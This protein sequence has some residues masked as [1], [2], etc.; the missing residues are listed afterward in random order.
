MVFYPAA[1]EEKFEDAAGEDIAEE[2]EEKEKDEL[3]IEENSE[4]NEE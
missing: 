2:T 3:E 1:N 4:Q